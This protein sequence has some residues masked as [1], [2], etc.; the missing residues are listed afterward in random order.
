[1]RDWD[2]MDVTPGETANDFLGDPAGGFRAL[3]SFNDRFVDVVGRMLIGSARGSPLNEDWDGGTTT[4]GRR[5]RPLTWG[6]S[7]LNDNGVV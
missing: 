7:P 6:G 4:V 2:L 5:A 3:K 1:M